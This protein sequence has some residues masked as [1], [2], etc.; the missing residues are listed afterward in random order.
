[1]I[2]ALLTPIALMVSPLSAQLPEAY[3]HLRIIEEVVEQD[4]CVEWTDVAVHAGW[5]VEDLPQLFRYMYRES[6]CIPTAC[7]TP[8]RPDLRRCRDWGL[9]QINDYSWKGTI[10]RLGLDIEQMWDPYANL[11]FARWLYETAEGDGGCGWSPWYG[12]C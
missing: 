3:E 1:M 6:R 7:S 11:W 2:H 10:R 9:M 5:P 8:D 12:K 4:K